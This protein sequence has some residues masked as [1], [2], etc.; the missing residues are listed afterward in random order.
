MYTNV[1]TIG[2]INLKTFNTVQTDSYELYKVEGIDLIK[3]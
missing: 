1:L 2:A 3:L